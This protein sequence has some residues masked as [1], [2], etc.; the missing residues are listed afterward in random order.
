[1][2]LLYRGFGLLEGV[3]GRADERAGFD[4][5]EAHRLAG[6]LICAE[7]VGMDVTDDWK[8]ITRGLQV[9]A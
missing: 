5:F 1:M 6:D 3:V 7:L 4:V 8:M 2:R 9:L